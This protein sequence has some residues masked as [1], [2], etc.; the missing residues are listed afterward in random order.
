MSVALRREFRSMNVTRIPRFVSTAAAI[1]VALAMPVARAQQPAPAPATP[2]QAPA[3][4]VARIAAE[5]ANV[6]LVAGQPIRFSITAYDSAGA[7]IQN[8]PLRTSGPRGVLRYSD[9]QL[10][11][12]QA[13]K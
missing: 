8:A 13:G 7:V 2:A 11:G 10:T 4:R 3:P 9:G 1:S 12:L 5:P 6:T